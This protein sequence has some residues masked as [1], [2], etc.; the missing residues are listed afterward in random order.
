MTTEQEVLQ[1]IESANPDLINW[2]D[3]NAYAALGIGADEEGGA[4]PQGETAD[5]TE[6]QPAPAPAAPPAAPAAT[7]PSAPP[8]ATPQQT[9]P[10]AEAEGIASRDGK[11]IIPYAVL[12]ETRRQAQEA[13]ARVQ[14]LERQLAEK[15]SSASPTGNNALADKAAADPNSLTDAE[16]EELAAD[17]P[18][19]AKPLRLLR[20][21]AAKVEELSSSAAAPRAAP[22]AATAPA[23][24][25]AQ[26]EQDAFDAGLAAN[27][28]LAQWMSQRG[29]EWTRATQI[30]KVLAADPDNAGLTYAQRFE[31]VQRMVAAEFGHALPA[32]PAPTPKPAAPAAPVAQ[33]RAFPSLSDMG[34]APPQSEDDAMASMTTT[35]MLARFEQM[36]VDQLERLAGVRY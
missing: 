24:D 17:F 28:L 32:A 20:Q 29:R 1:R 2:N 7:A 27:P 16:I 10:P 23:V 15:V 13:T 5:T 34:G 30:D 12:Q 35:D 31:K 25:P 3:A 6:A 4:D 18:Q 9:S 8:G 36:P 19:L 26:A 22:T 21:A 14:E 11:H 33:Q